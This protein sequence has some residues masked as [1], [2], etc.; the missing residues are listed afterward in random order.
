METLSDQT[1]CDIERTLKFTV[2]QELAFRSVLENGD[3]LVTLPYKLRKGSPYGLKVQLIE[4]D[5]ISNPE[6]AADDEK[7]AGGCTT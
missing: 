5:R 1:D 7:I 6:F 3:A 2:F 4:A